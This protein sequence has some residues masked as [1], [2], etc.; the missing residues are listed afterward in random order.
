M[1]QHLIIP[2]SSLG[3][4]YDLELHSWHQRLQAFR[5][6]EGDTK[7]RLDGGLGLGLNFIS[8]FTANSA[9]YE[10]IPKEYLHKTA[11]FPEHQFQMLWLAANVEQAAQI[12]MTRPLLLVLICEHY[13][14]DNDTAKEVAQLGQRDILKRLGYHGSKAAL[15]F[16][17]KIALNF[18]RDIELQ[19][20]KKQLDNR[21]CRYQ[22][23]KH[24]SVVNF[25]A[26]SIDNRYPFL[27][28]T[29][30]GQ[31]I[32]GDQNIKRVSLVAYL[33]D[34]LQLGVQLGINDPIQ[35]IGTLESIDELEQLHQQWVDR[36]NDLRKQQLRPNDAD[37]PYPI[38]IVG[39]ENIIAIKNYD[40][41]FEEG[42]KM[43]HC[44]AIYHQQIASGEYCAFSMVKPE[45]MTI[46]VKI[47]E[48]ETTLIQI[49]QI[50]GVCNSL[51]SNEVREQA[52]R[53][54]ETEKENL[55]TI[56]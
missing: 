1:S 42:T 16:I 45:R 49:D 46:G 23:F 47:I 37:K 51:P 44:I 4:G 17:D 25:N 48:K 41:L 20:I 31:A 5:V 26:L 35:R 18:E 40:E 22:V 29:R 50:S 27:T 28:A 8:Q 9:W 14:V 53:W 21:F 15:K 34:A 12:L 7:E 32:A 55:K 36:S 3:L 33:L 2:T 19:H 56:L 39:N 13:S 11:P 10:S 43:K 52:Y 30:F 24:Y 6:F 54:I 38:T